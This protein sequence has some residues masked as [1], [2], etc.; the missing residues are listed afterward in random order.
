MKSLR[1]KI[2]SK[3]DFNNLLS[4][5]SERIK[6]NQPISDNG[7]LDGMIIGLMLT[8]YDF[9]LDLILDKEMGAVLDGT[10]QKLEQI[11]TWIV[12]NENELC[13]LI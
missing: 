4:T 7:M 13:K 6:L 3:A 12:N 10:L 9:T 1:K 11:C 2:K 8:T 5:L